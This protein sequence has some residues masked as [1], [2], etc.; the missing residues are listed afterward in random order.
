MDTL[1]YLLARSL[2]AAIQA[3]P[4]VWVARIGR[5]AGALAYALDG[6]HRRVALENLNACFRAEKSPEE[7]RACARENFRRIGENFACAVKTASMPD[8]AIY[9]RLE[10]AG[11][12]HF[13]PPPK[14]G[15]GHSRVIA[16][17]HFGNFELYARATLFVPGY[18]FATTYRAL[19]QPALNRL[20]QGLRNQS[21]CLFF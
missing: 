18:Q 17:G 16:I 20:L 11:G 5:A 19:R 15:N 21:G 1:L 13:G 7:I 8:T 6:R 14:P 4:L 9:Q 2:V 3:L 12:E 10:Y